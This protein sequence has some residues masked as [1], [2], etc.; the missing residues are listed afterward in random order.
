M[1]SV[2]SQIY[3]KGIIVKTRRKFLKYFTMIFST[4]TASILMMS[5]GAK[6]DTE[7]EPSPEWPPKDE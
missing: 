6:P 3:K 4:F 1:A 7:T 2:F 5:C